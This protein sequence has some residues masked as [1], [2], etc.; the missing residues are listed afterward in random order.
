MNQL[1]VGH[2]PEARH[3]FVPGMVDV[4]IQP[5]PFLATLPAVAEPGKEPFDVVL[6]AAV[7]EYQHIALRPAGFVNQAGGGLPAGVIQRRFVQCNQNT[8]ERVLPDH[9]GDFLLLLSA[10]SISFWPGAFTVPSP[11]TYM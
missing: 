1:A 9:G 10:A 4:E 3:A 11:L 8:L 5:F 7:T 6:R 2:P